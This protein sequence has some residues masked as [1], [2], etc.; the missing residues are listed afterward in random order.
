MSHVDARP[1]NCCHWARRARVNRPPLPP[2]PPPPLS[3]GRRVT[4]CKHWLRVCAATTGQKS[5]C[6]PER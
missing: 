2:P 1:A 3:L 4:G 6:C 5:R